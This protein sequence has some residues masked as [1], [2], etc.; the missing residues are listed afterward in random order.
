MVLHWHRCLV[1]SLKFETNE[2]GDNKTG[3]FVK[4][5]FNVAG[6]PGNKDEFVKFCWLQ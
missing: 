5:D 4:P 1:P 3:H 2:I 6:S